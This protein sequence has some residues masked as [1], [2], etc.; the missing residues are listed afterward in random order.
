MLDNNSSLE[1]FNAFNLIHTPK[2]FDQESDAESLKFNFPSKN[3]LF[4]EITNN[5]DE[6]YLQTKNDNK[7]NQLSNV[8]KEKK[9]NISEKKCI[10]KESLLK[11]IDEI[12]DALKI[13]ENKKFEMDGIILFYL[14][15]FLERELNIEAYE[16]MERKEKLSDDEIGNEITKLSSIQ[17]LLTKIKDI[18][19]K[20][21]DG[22]LDDES[23]I[24]HLKEELILFE[25]EYENNTKIRKEIKAEAGNNPEP[26]KNLN[27]TIKKFMVNRLKNAKNFLL[28]LYNKTDD[29]IEPEEKEIKFL[30]KK[31]KALENEDKEG[32]IMEAEESLSLLEKGDNDKIKKYRSDNISIMFKRNLIQ[33][34]F[35]DWINEGELNKNEKLI[36]LDPIIFQGSITLKDLEGKKLKQIYSKKISPKSKTFNQFHNIYIIKKAKGIKKIKLN[37]YFE[38]A[39]KIFFTEEINEDEIKEIIEEEKKD[40]TFIFNKNDMIKGLMC[41]E[42]YINEKTRGENITLEKKLIEVFDKLKEKYL[43]K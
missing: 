6:F 27:I 28:E 4:S 22:E 13:S 36:K 3:S 40:K 31:R 42:D 25:E 24:R 5:F 38:Q 2:A 34:V 23:E 26:I 9:I 20:V 21:K 19:I 30:E 1:E 32:D 37:L 16:L 43:I 7:I 29:E 14:S 18:K 15:T 33:Q 11:I 10:S 17:F 39:L 8:A 41:E 12:N 35:L